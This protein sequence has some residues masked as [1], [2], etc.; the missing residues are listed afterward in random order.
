[1]LSS[2][3]FEEVV[4]DPPLSE[5]YFAATPHF[6]VKSSLCFVLK[7]MR[8]LR[9]RTKNRGSNKPVLNE[10][11][12]VGVPYKHLAIYYYPITNELFSVVGQMQSY[13]R[14][15]ICR[16]EEDFKVEAWP[17]IADAPPVVVV[18]TRALQLIQCTN[19][20]D[21]PTVWNNHIRQIIT[22]LRRQALLCPEKYN[23]SYCAT[24]SHV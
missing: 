16:H 7:D 14:F 2:K 23:E 6:A 19:D 12:F 11:L 8:C 3:L 18:D 22:I 15:N 21:D 10:L 9:P 20:V 24:R 13:K 1:M 5:K 17:A 4:V